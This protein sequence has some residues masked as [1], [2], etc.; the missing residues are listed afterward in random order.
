MELCYSDYA[1]IRYNI[2][3]KALHNY[4]LFNT[5]SRKVFL[6]SILGK[7]PC[8]PAALLDSFDDGHIAVLHP[9]C[10]IPHQKLY[11]KQYLNSTKNQLLMLATL[12]KHDHII[13][14]TLPLVLTTVTVEE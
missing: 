8:I 5:F 12:I 4:P 13:H 9:S 7:V 14:F 11:K 1:P 10:Y 3:I 2:I 6:K